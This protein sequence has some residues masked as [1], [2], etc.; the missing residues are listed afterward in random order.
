MACM[1]ATVAP[2]TKNPPGSHQA[3]FSILVGARGFE[4]PTTCTPCRY[5]TRLRYAPKKNEIISEPTVMASGLQVIY[6]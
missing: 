1:R 5:A 4:P 6:S 2:K 3:G